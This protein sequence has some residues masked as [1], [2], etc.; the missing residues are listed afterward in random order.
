MPLVLAPSVNPI[1]PVR[2]SRD[3]DDQPSTAPAIPC[4]HN[5]RSLLT[6]KYPHPL[7]PRN[8]LSQANF[9]PTLTPKPFSEDSNAPQV[10]CCANDGGGG[11][12]R[13]V[14]DIAKLSVGREEYYTRE[15]ATDH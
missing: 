14:A 3:D 2:A 7:T 5:C 9:R 10:R 8:R 6:K 4:F 1:A 12:G 11:S 13:M 15:L